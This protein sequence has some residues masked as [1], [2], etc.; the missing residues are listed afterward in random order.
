[1][2]TDLPSDSDEASLNSA[3]IDAATLLRSRLIAGTP[4][5]NEEQATR[6]ESDVHNFVA[7]LIIMLPKKGRAHRLK[8]MLQEYHLAKAVGQGQAI[9]SQIANYLQR[10]L[11]N[12]CIDEGRRQAT[13][14][15]H[16]RALANRPDVGPQPIAEPSQELIEREEERRVDATI[17]EM[18]VVLREIIRLRHNGMTNPQIAERLGLT[19][20]AVAGR[21]HRA[22]H[23]LKQR[24]GRSC[25]RNRTSKTSSE[26]SNDREGDRSNGPD[27]LPFRDEKPRQ[28]SA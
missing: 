19:Y 16:E 24:L 20:N 25:S 4:N 13:R 9:L 27:L 10:S 3:L 21:L 11:R 7:R 5:C 22:K 2:E 28:R 26:G 1:M 6:I 23:W 18:P 14:A 15:K 17:D 12:R 8:T